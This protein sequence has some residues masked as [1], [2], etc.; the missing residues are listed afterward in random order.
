MNRVEGISF[1]PECQGSGEAAA[2][3]VNQ[4]I[5]TAPEESTTKLLEGHQT[6][7][8][9]KVYKTTQKKL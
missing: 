6:L 1:G 7:E 2:E 3:S 8:E 9:E 4:L 5:E